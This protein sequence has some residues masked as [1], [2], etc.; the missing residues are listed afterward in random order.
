MQCSQHRPLRRHHSHGPVGDWRRSRTSDT[1]HSAVDVA[2][3]KRL[4]LLLCFSAINF[5]FLPWVT[6]S[7]T[8]APQASNIRISS[9]GARRIIKSANSRCSI[10]RLGSSGSLQYSEGIF[11]PR[12][13]FDWLV[14]INFPNNNYNNHNC[15]CQSEVCFYSHTRRMTNAWLPGFASSGQVAVAHLA[16]VRLGTT[17]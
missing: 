3:S 12:L 7:F 16:L 13:F 4:L 1:W 14:L 8:L 11:D 10:L 17:S 6:G 15:E 5:T 2:L 9:S